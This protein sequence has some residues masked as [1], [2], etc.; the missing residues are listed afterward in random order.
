MNQGRIVNKSGSVVRLRW[1]ET[2]VRRNDEWFFSFLIG[3]AGFPT[4]IVWILHHHKNSYVEAL[5]PS[6][7]VFGGGVFMEIIKIPNR[8]GVF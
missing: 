5:S 7:T 2:E 3:F 6:V 4:I 8:T 1:V